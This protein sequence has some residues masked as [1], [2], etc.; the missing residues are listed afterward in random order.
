M[1]YS[2]NFSPVITSEWRWFQKTDP[3]IT[4]APV[5]D[6]RGWCTLWL[7]YRLLY[8][9]TVDVLGAHSNICS[10]TKRASRQIHI[11]Y[12]QAIGHMHVGLLLRKLFIPFFNWQPFPTNLANKWFELNGNTALE[13][14]KIN[15][16]MLLI[17][18]SHQCWRVY[19]T[20]YSLMIG[21]SQ[22]TLHLYSFY[23]N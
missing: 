23:K 12:T 6:K 8:V 13:N 17:K 15:I 11:K 20:K 5:W 4:G 2:L 22:V 16:Q 21:S 19:T 14:I 3:S 1:F 10:Y 18:S 7:S 9:K